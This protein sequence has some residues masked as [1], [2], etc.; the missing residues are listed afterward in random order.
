VVAFL[1]LA[2]AAVAAPAHAE[3]P[4]RVV[5]ADGKVVAIE[6]TLRLEDDKVVATN[7]GGT[8]LVLVQGRGEVLPGLERAIAGMAPGE[9][10]QGTLAPAEAYGDVDPQLFVE[11]E[12]SRIPEPDRRAGAQVFLRDE[13]GAR[14]V[15]RIHEV[16]GD[17]VVVDLNHNLAGNPIRYEVRVLRVEAPP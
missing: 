12:T 5:V 8:P 9:T 17:R 13:S 4:A 11:V 14:R 1:G 7:V 16:R 15:V 10:K 3:E 6:Y 2:A